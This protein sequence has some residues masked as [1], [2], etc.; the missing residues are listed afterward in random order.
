MD[1]AVIR[2]TASRCKS[3]FVNKPRVGSHARG[4]VRVIR[5][6]EHAIGCA[7]RG[8]ATGDTVAAKG[9]CPSH[10]IAHRDVDCA[11]TERKRP[12]RCHR[13]I[14]NCAGSRWNAAHHWLAVLIENANGRRGKLFLYRHARVSVARFSPRQKSCRNENC[15]PKN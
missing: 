9:P 7:G 8:I 6:T 14:D 2:K 5:R 12:I 4:A 1:T 10:R 13:H 11:R 3:E 15:D